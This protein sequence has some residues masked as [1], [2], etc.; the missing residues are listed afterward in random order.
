M[1]T[2]EAQD[3]AIKQITKPLQQ[4]N[5]NRQI[6]LANPNYNRNDKRILSFRT[7]A[8]LIG[9][10][11]LVAFTRG[12]GPSLPAGTVGI[13]EVKNINSGTTI[14]NIVVAGGA[15]SIEETNPEFK[16]YVKNE[17]FLPVPAAQ[18]NLHKAVSCIADFCIWFG[19]AQFSYLRAPALVVSLRSWY[20]YYAKQTP[21]PLQYKRQL[22]QYKQFTQKKINYLTSV[23]PRHFKLKPLLKEYCEANKNDDAYNW[24]LSLSIL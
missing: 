17:T 20:D 8:S 23:L 7:G 1:Y 3:K 19:T 22:L 13:R 11:E 15:P 24:F 16:N 6:L 9:V 12:T 18:G 14:S 2:L 5:N 4:A 21:K 10:L